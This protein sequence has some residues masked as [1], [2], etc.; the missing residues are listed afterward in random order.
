MT[1]T[2]DRITSSMQ[3]QF[4][5]SKSEAFHLI[6]S[7]LENIR[8]SLESGEDV[9][10]SGVGRF[11]LKEMGVRQGG[12]PRRGKG[13]ILQ[14]RRVMAF[15]CSAMLRGPINGKNAFEQPLRR[16]HRA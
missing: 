8:R 2:K 4:G 13:L 10:I 11:T 7:V 15:K 3:S 6:E 1:L 14:R 12:K 5:L 9:F 16:A